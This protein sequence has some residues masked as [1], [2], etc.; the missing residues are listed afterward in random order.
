MKVDKGRTTT[1]KEL[2]TMEKKLT[3]I[4]SRA[5]KEVGKRWKEYM[6]KVNEKAARLYDDI[7][8][9]K[10]PEGK[11]LAEKAYKDYVTNATLRNQHFKTLTEQYAKEILD[12]NKT[13]VAYV[14]GKMP[15]V[16]ATNYNAIGTGIQSQ[17]KGYSFELVDAA[18]VKSLATKDETLLPYKVVNGK[19]DVRWNT[20]AVNSEVL[21]GIIQGESIP[22]ISK[23][24]RNV[25]EMNL[26]SSIRNARTSTTSAE[27]RG[28]MDSFHAAQ[29]KGVVLHKIW[30]ATNDGRTREAHILLDGQEQEV[31]E[32]FDS[33]LGPIM[34]PGDPNADPANVYNCRCTMVTKVLGFGKLNTFSEEDLLNESDED[35]SYTFKEMKV[36]KKPE[37]YTLD[38]IMEEVERMPN[39]REYD[40]EKK[41]LLPLA[42]E[43]G[44]ATASH[45]YANI[46][47][48]EI[49]KLTI[50]T[51]VKIDDLYTEQ[52]EVFTS[53]LEDLAESFDG[54]IISGI[55]TEDEPVGI[56]VAKYQDKLI[57]VDGNNRTNLA[58]LKGQDEIDVML[59][60]LDEFTKKKKKRMV[61]GH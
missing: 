52:A 13:A 31:D 22:D 59:I 41:N 17:L 5:E 34:Y 19:K 60:D 56:T 20:S 33:E 27:N 23:R 53:R 55:A 24:L 37:A 18:T 10:T 45:I 4:Y 28:R 3:G 21:Q 14:N 54:K 1:D 15:D 26:S 36:E 8:A 32:P 47:D 16:Y 11:R 38:E 40:D 35:T 12:V 2:Q 50:E 48:D 46:P 6:D 51:R 44:E 39:A 61:H 43:N 9:A 58:I 49:E 57:V 30:M 7:K 42:N 29:E 25:T